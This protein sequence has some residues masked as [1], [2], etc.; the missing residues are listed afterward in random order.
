[1]SIY[2]NIFVKT[3]AGVRD[4]TSEFSRIVGKPFALIQTD[5]GDVYETEILGTRVVIIGNPG[6]SDAGGDHLNFSQYQ[7]QIDIGPVT[8]GKAHDALIQSMSVHL[9]GEIRARMKHPTMVTEGLRKLVG[10]FEL[11]AS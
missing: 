9:A 3:N 1:M 6:L 8:G 10:A 4:F 11:A 5:V 7:V 2:F